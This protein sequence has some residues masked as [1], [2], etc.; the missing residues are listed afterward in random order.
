MKFDRADERLSQITAETIDNEQQVRAQIKRMF[1]DVP[2]RVSQTFAYNAHRRATEQEKKE[3]NSSRLR[4]K[5]DLIEDQDFFEKLFKDERKLWW[6]GRRT[7]IR[8]R[9]NKRRNHFLLNAGYQEDDDV[10]E[11]EEPE[12]EADWR[13]KSILE[14]C[15]KSDYHVHLERLSK[16]M[17]PERQPLATRTDRTADV[18][19]SALRSHVTEQNRPVL[20]HELADF[21]NPYMTKRSAMERLLSER[22]VRNQ[23]DE[24][25]LPRL[26]EKE[27]T[28]VKLQ[29]EANLP[30]EVLEPLAAFRG[31]TRWHFDARERLGQKLSTVDT[32]L[33]A[34][35]DTKGNPQAVQAALPEN[36]DVQ[37]DQVAGLHHPWRNHVGFSSAVPKDFAGGQRMG[38]PMN[39]IDEQLLKLRYPTLQR[40]AHTLPKDPKWR[41][42]VVRTIRVL[43]RSKHWDFRNKLRAV[44]SMKEIYDNMRPSE[45]YNRR[46]D[47]KLVVNRV[48]SHLKRKYAR[49]AQYIKTFPKKF[50]R[51]KTH[52][53]YRASLT[54]TQAKKKK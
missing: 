36:A 48:P 18:L 14:D 6:N 22:C 52:E 45:Y 20:T 51:K 54:A 30:P 13:L 49:N 19:A 4:P 2:G 39:A 37:P 43:E 44:N 1:R 35:V 26:L 31:D 8:G 53:W 40:V 10:Y 3:H 41:A 46:L 27:P 38:Q 12:F 34:I 50:L 7:E 21:E 23:L 32:A 9:R 25:V 33:A 29:G 16:Q 5:A 17:I 42:H 24:R 28:L 15:W 11:A 47:E